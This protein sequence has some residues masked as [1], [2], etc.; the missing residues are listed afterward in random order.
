MEMVAQ[1][2]L[3]IVILGLSTLIP[4]YAAIPAKTQR[5]INKVNKDGPYLGIVIPN[6]FE[7]NPLLNHPTFISSNLTID[8]AGMSALRNYIF[9]LSTNI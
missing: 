2:I 7:M 8:S 4:C 1:R 9:Q 5:L 3:V 6:M